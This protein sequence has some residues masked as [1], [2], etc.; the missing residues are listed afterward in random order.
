MDGLSQLVY[1]H[2]YMCVLL[3][4]ELDLQTMIQTMATQLANLI[5]FAK[6]AHCLHNTM[7]GKWEPTVCA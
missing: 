3:S 6:S 5:F 1:P 7:L 2:A 4:C